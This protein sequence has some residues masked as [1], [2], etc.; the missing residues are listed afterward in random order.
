VAVATTL[1]AR[2]VIGE[3]LSVSPTMSAEQPRRIPNFFVISHHLYMRESLHLL[4]ELAP[5]RPACRV[6]L[7]TLN[8]C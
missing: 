2:V 4:I 5:R 3:M 7:A 8:E 6:A 1:S